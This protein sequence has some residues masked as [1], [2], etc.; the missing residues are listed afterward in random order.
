M[1][2]QIVRVTDE[3]TKADLAITLEILNAAAKAISRRG[4]VGVHGA[5]YNVAHARIDAVLDDWERAKA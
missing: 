2:A 4:Y 5:E 1:T 3:D